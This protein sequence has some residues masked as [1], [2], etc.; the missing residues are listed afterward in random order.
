MRDLK[1]LTALAGR[2][3]ALAKPGD[4]SRET[5]AWWRIENAAAPRATV[6]LHGVVGDEWD[7]N[8]SAS[9]VRALADVSAKDIDL[10]INSGGG[11]VFDGIAIYGALLEHPARVTAHVDGIAAS[12]ASFIAMAGDEIEIS[13]PAKMMIHDAAGLAIGD[14]RTMREMADLLDDLSTTIAEVYADRAG[15]KVSEW[16]AAMLAETWYGSAEAV[17]AG[18]ADRVANERKITDDDAKNTLRSQT[19]RA[20]ARVTLK[21]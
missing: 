19:I 12:A 17:A 7:G 1:R 6:Y 16:R 13:K 20:R 21:G 5:S 14:A 2:A 9:F 11:L 4:V 3:R 18:L 8:D 10:R 15:G